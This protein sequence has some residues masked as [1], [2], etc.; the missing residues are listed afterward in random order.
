MRF[1]KKL[2]TTAV[3]ASLAL[4]AGAANAYVHADFY[5][6]FFP[7]VVKDTNRT[8]VITVISANDSRTTSNQDLH[9]QYW[10]KSTTAANTAACEPNSSFMQITPND[11][12]SF[13]T[14]GLLGFPLFGDTTNAAPL[15]A[16]IAYA[17]PRHGYLLVDDANNDLAGGFWMEL[18]FA[19]GG[20]YGDIGLGVYNDT[21][22]TNELFNAHSLL[23]DTTASITNASPVIFWPASVASTVFTVTPIGTNMLNSDNNSVVMQVFNSN[24]VQGAYDRNENGVDGTVPQTVRCVGRLTAAQLMPGVVA[25]AAWA[26]T[27]GWGYLANLGNGNALPAQTD[28]C[29]ASGDCK[30]VVYQVDTSN[31]AGAGKFMSNATMITSYNGGN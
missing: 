4:S 15:G 30:A 28:P 3:G 9:I 29:S 11:I 7:Y 23:S 19:N 20:A 27:G 18:D 31:A 1:N 25:N 8:T 21:D 5:A 26:A 13:D 14:A 24:L 17:S 22:L 6:I 10:T 16:S 12:V 2:V